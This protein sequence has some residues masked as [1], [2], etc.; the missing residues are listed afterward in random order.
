MRGS[1]AAAATTVASGHGA[2]AIGGDVVDSV[3]VTAPNSRVIVVRVGDPAGAL[4]GFLPFR[5][6]PR[7]KARRSP[8]V[9]RPE[10]F[11]DHL[12]R[13]REVEELLASP[14]DLNVHGEAGIGKTYVLTNA[15]AR[16]EA[17]AHRDGVVYLFAKGRPLADLL[18]ALFEE[19]YVCKPP[20]VVSPEH[21]ARELAEKRALVVVD[22]VELDRDEV[23]RLVTAAP[24]SRFIVASRQRVLWDG[25]QLLLHGLTAEFALALLEREL[26]RLLRPGERAAAERLCALLSG[27]PLAIRQA[28]ALIADGRSTFVDVVAR[29]EAAGPGAVAAQS[30]E[31]LT[32]DERRLVEAVTP[33][34][35]EAVRVEHIGKLAGI[36]APQLFADLERRGVLV[37]HS[38]KYSLAPNLAEVLARNEPA[39]VERALAYFVDWA[40]KRRELPAEQHADG[41]ALV[42]LV[43]TA[44][45]V[46]Q[47]RGAIRLAQEIDAGLATGRRIGSWGEVHELALEAAR[48][49]GDR[50]AE[51]WALHQRGT[52]KVALGETASGV[53]DLEAALRLRSDLGDDAGRA[54][55]EWNLG[56]VRRIGPAG[57]ARVV[58]LPFLMILVGLAALVLAG[59]A[60][61]AIWLT[62]HHRHHPPP[63]VPVAL[64]VARA[65]TGD[66]SVTSDPA[67]IDCG[68]SCE[69]SFEAG[70]TIVLRAS[71]DSG[72]RFMAWKGAC[73]GQGV[74]RLTMRSDSR[75]SATFAARAPRPQPLTVEVKGQGRVAGPAGLSCTR[76]CTKRFAPHTAVRLT[77][78]P[79]V[80]WRLAGWSIAKCHARE[81]LLRVD[82]SVIVTA[83]FAPL[84][85]PMRLTVQTAGAGSG[86]VTS[87]PAKI[88]CPPHCSGTFAGGGSITLVAHGSSGSSFSGWSGD[89]TGTAPCR[90]RM[91]AAHAVTA[92]FA[93]VAVT[94]KVTVD[95]VGEGSVRS[96]PSGL[97]CPTACSA[98]F[99]AG[100]RVTLT[101]IAASGSV[102]T[103]WDVSACATEATCP[104]QVEHD[105]SAKATF[106][107][108]KQSLTVKVAGSG[109]VVSTPTGIECASI[110]RA[111]FSQDEAVTLTAAP[112]KGW[113]FAGWS[114]DCT[115]RVA[116]SLTLDARHSVIARFVHTFSV[117]VA[118][119]GGGSVVTAPSGIDCGRS[120]SF[121]FDANSTLTL[122]A[123]PDATHAFGAWGDACKGQ[124]NPCTL[125]VTAPLFVSVTFVHRPASLTIKA[126]GNGTV[127][128]APTG[129]PC[130]A[131]C[132]ATFA[133]GTPVTLTANPATGWMFTGWG[134]DC[135]GTSKNCSLTLDVD[136][137]VT[138]QFEQTFQ[139]IVK[140]GGGGSVVSSPAGIACGAICGWPLANGTG[141]TLTAKPNTN[142]IFGTWSG[143]C[144][145][146][147]NPCVL[148]ITAATTVGVT[149]IAVPP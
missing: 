111:S 133:Y 35:G 61:T 3:I 6:R 88:E 40:E 33:F 20:F 129:N 83:T 115:G 66:G 50:S 146:Q 9:R 51:A 108:R 148:K 126:S 82:D 15:L 81:C 116:C 29:I 23:Q 78:S 7:T 67:G 72:S 122:T 135:K 145:R 60:G 46:G 97:Y 94:H 48:R 36:D 143:A 90:V 19:F 75:V 101:A 54:A 44:A 96:A 21:A 53:D 80:G 77:A 38:P 34:R 39:A 103:G 10:P 37:S 118:N 134:G 109:N 119:L 112:L 49:S 11:A 138:A 84:G 105:R 123:S 107:V 140:N 22:S 136:R 99:A 87:A 149:F 31:N 130:N 13:T 65:G 62:R 30:V 100:T 106:A 32:E 92:T 79:G 16:D 28:A 95:V 68:G 18:Q 27:N 59:G 56:A 5:R 102:F 139:L 1:R 2:V 73:S 86:T 91:D 71:P 142:H 69:K 12:D 8:V 141:V 58:R 42:A 47:D 57:T 25:D 17:L 125:S 85:R 45:Q 63:T 89:C 70:A 104:L 114:G 4:L 43:E 131:P 127:T 137:S 98:H 110:C 76:R 132:F 74:C 117:K 24:G 41:P 55:T 14:S 93:R 147:K 144:A 128:S 113:R 52:R 121:S 120:C 124:P 26:G 64:A